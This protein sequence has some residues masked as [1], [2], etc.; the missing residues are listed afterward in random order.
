MHIACSPKVETTRFDSKWREHLL[1]LEHLHVA[2]ATF[3][4]CFSDICC[5]NIANG[6]DRSDTHNAIH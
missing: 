6:S 2:F 3:V 1:M 4:D 5:W